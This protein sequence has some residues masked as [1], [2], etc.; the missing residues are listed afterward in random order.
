K[1]EKQKPWRG[2][3]EWRG[4]YLAW[5]GAV[6]L[7]LLIVL[8]S[9]TPKAEHAGHVVFR[10]GT[11]SVVLFVAGSVVGYSMLYAFYS[12]IA[13]SSGDRFMLSL[14]LPLAFSLVW[15]AEGIIRR[16]NRREASP[17]ISRGYLAAQWVLFAVL[18]WRLF[19]ILRVPQFYDG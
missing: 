4:I 10:H 6:L 13:T 8:R 1:I 3:L 5:L 9:A 11:V 12:P 19:E 7:A 17:W 14:Y 16:I 2:I 15:G 18:S